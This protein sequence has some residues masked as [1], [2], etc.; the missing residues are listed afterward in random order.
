MS[1]GFP[2]W[3]LVFVGGLAIVAAAVWAT[4]PAVVPAP[5]AAVWAAC[6]EPI[7]LDHGDDD[8]DLMLVRRPVLDGPEGSSDHDPAVLLAN[9]ARPIRVELDRNE[10]EAYADGPAE[11]PQGRAVAAQAAAAWLERGRLEVR[12]SDGSRFLI[13]A[14]QSPVQF[15]L[16]PEAAYPARLTRATAASPDGAGRVILPAGTEVEIALPPGQPMAVEQ[17]RP[18][19][20]AP[21]VLPEV[22]ASLAPDV[23]PSR[24]TPPS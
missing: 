6:F 3:L 20:G 12:R 18:L 1:A 23:Q 17:I 13:G 8:I 9:A 10:Q 7:A 21:L 11:L 2:R 14:G 22:A 24:E 5:T 4:T 16:D 15:E 19:W